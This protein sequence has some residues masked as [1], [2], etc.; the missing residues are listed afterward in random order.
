MNTIKQHSVKCLVKDL[1]L[2]L[3]YSEDRPYEI[4]LS[5][6]AYPTQVINQALDKIE[7]KK[8][9]CRS[10]YIKDKEMTIV[11]IGTI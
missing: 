2:G 4:Q 9:K 8:I 3:K 6:F 11:R 7:S 10:F 1:K 5:N